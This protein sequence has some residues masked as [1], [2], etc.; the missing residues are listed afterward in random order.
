MLKEGFDA[1]P[2]MAL[3][4]FRFIRE[5]MAPY[6][7]PRMIEFLEEFPKTIS[8]KVKRKDL[9]ALDRER[10]ERGER[11]PEEHYETD[12]ARELGLDRR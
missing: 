2:E 1:G 10:K 11:R 3:E 5:Q 12:F 7:R 9:R 4:L 6:K 8:A